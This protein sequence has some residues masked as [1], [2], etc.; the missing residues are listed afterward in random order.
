MRP[1]VTW[2]AN[3]IDSR[4]V[5]ALSA[6]SQVVRITTD[7]ARTLIIEPRVSTIITNPSFSV[8][9][10]ILVTMLRH[11]ALVVFL[12]RLN[13][14]A[15]PRRFLFRDLK[16]SVYVLPDRPSYVDMYEE[17]KPDILKAQTDSIEYGWFLFNGRG[18]FRVIG[19]TPSEVRSA[20]IEEG[21]R[22]GTRPRK[23]KP[24]KQL[25]EAA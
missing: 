9:L 18:Q 15:G 6:R 22:N 13:W 11:G 20:E 24:K 8:S 23:L 4:Y 3:E 25:K 7:D 5:P 21:R 10:E 2:H 12:Q 16:P 19:D 14:A 1:D 17:D